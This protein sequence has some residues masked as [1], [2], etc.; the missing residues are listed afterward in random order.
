M[1]QG[2][3]LLSE[4]IPGA[5]GLS[6][7]SF[8][9]DARRTRAWIA[10]LPRANAGATQQSLAQ[11]LDSL[12]GQRLDGGTRL[13][14]LEELRI[15]VGESLG[16]LKREY[17]GSA[18][19]LAPAKAAAAR[20][21]EEFHTA[22]AHA[23]RRAAVEFCA[24]SG[25]VPMLRGGSVALALARA[26]WHYKEALSVA[27]R[28]YRAPSAGI[29]QGLHRVY[30]FAVEAK[31]DGRGADDALAGAP[32]EVRTVYLQSLLM[33][34]SH[35]LAFSQAEQDQLWQATAEFAP[36][37]TL[38]G[39]APED[40]APVVPGDADRGPGPGVV[41]EAASR[42]LD[43]APFVAEVDA[44]LA[45]ARDGASLLMPARGQGIRVSVEFLRR[46]KRSFG[47]SAART[48][49]RLPATHGMRSVFGLSALHFHLAGQRD[50]DAFMRHATQHIVHQPDRA[51]WVGGGG[52][53][54]PVHEA[55][56]LD[57]SLGGY[58][59]AWDHAEQIRARVGEL[60][61]LTLSD[62]D[63]L[64]EWMLGVV[65][66]L[67]YEN[68]GGLS[69]GVELLARRALAVGLRLEDGSEP[70]RA[71]QMDAMQDDGDMHFLA[72]NTLDCGAT[73]IE[74]VRDESACDLKGE[75]GVE[76][77]LAGVDVLLNA[78]DYALLRPLRADLVADAS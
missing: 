39:R 27:W 16:L 57:Q 31:L 40:N 53:R 13:A 32:V 49:R 47:L 75:A 38:A 15:A 62:G 18:L 10:A 28:V 6:T 65:R 69:A 61:G 36:R 45:R 12:A 56:V 9:A 7:A 70:L 44:A 8:P 4:G 46:L 24:P 19:P 1:S 21:V 74:V 35:P 5:L 2:Y 78:G 17:A 11:A 55:R 29:W 68:D 52:A 72:P 25:N 63:E 14:V 60:V 23:Y 66:W 76:E 41:G 77:I 22:L 30:G 73:R 26:A 3:R 59:L 33:A 20:Q 67:R 34:I 37:C 54:V 58:R 64:P 42:W 51:N 43:M 71:L 50:F 48:H